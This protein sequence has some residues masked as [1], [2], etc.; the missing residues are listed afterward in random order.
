MIV[1]SLC[2]I[3]QDIGLM[4]SKANPSSLCKVGIIKEGKGERG[5]F[6]LKN[7]GYIKKNVWKRFFLSLLCVC[8]VCVRVVCVCLSMLW[9]SLWCVVLFLLVFSSF[10]FLEFFFSLFLCK[11]RFSFKS[12]WEFSKLNSSLKKRRAF[13]SRFSEMKWNVFNL[14]LKIFIIHIHN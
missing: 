10:S 14:I 6:L 9:L 13:F 7:R 4:R 3:R 2:S 8:C 11:C 1:M 5:S 12:E